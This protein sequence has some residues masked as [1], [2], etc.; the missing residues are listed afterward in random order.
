[1]EASPVYLLLYT[2]AVLLAFVNKHKC[3]S[4][5]KLICNSILVYWTA[6]GKDRKCTEC[7]SLKAECKW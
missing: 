4:L 5:V 6:G 2:P 7:G 1:M 3:L